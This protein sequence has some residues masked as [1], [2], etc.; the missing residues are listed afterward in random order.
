MNDTQKKYYHQMIKNGRAMPVIVGDRFAAMITFYVTDN[1]HEYDEVDAW[2]VFGDNPE[3]SI[4]YISQMLTDKHV[5]NHKFAF[6]Y[7]NR[8]KQYVK[9]NFPNVKYVCWRRWQKINLIVKIYKKEI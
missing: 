8:F 5:D 9:S 1:E 3:G 7:F 2:G 6:K 4:V